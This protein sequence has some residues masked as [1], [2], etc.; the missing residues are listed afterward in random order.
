MIYSFCIQAEIQ[1]EL[2][3]KNKKVHF[4]NI[5]HTIELECI[6]AL[7]DLCL[8]KLNLNKNKPH[9]AEIHS[10]YTSLVSHCF[11]FG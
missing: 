10:I 9:N 5:L 6:P 8:I 3:S 7:L 11:M 1:L 4:T 2:S